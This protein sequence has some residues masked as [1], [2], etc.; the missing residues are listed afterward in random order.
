M[1]A[2]SGLKKARDTTLM[3]R[4]LATEITYSKNACQLLQ[5][6]S[7][8]RLDIFGLVQQETCPKKDETV[9]IKW[10]IDVHLKVELLKSER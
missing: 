1:N 2:A 9:Y 3:C 7:M 8:Q 6:R 4:H 5:I 10:A